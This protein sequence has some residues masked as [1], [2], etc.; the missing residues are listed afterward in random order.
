MDDL[1]DMIDMHKGMRQIE[2]VP[3]FWL[4][5]I[6]SNPIR[7]VEEIAIIENRQNSGSYFGWFDW[8]NPKDYILIHET[9]RDPGTVYLDSI[10]RS[11]WYLRR[12]DRQKFYLQTNTRGAELAASIFPVAHSGTV[13]YFRIPD[14]SLALDEM[15]LPSPKS[16]SW[17]VQEV[18]SQTGV[19]LEVE[20]CGA[21]NGHNVVSASTPFLNSVSAMIGVETDL[22]FRG[23][24]LGS[25]AV[26]MLASRLLE[27]GLMPVYASD[28]SNA[29][30]MRIANSLFV[31][32]ID[33]EFL[34]IGP[35]HLRK[36][37]DSPP[38]DPDSLFME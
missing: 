28:I 37:E 35:W 6:K 32:H 20:C 38:Q 15:H 5:A 7:Y 33:L 14:Y 13:R 21:I 11:Q 12:I 23:Q 1:N 3:E 22:R 25:C 18:T 17:L 31:A 2:E 8:R 34:F 4:K 24:G 9:G 36:P 26:G 29:P 10:K 30:S 27:L 16:V 19:L